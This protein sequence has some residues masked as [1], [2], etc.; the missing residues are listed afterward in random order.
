MVK[1]L[2]ANAGDI[3]ERCRFSPRVGKI[4]R[5]RA[6]QPTPV[7]LPGQSHGQRNLEGYCPLGLKESD[8]TERTEHAHMHT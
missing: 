1:S 5:R 2:P 3:R 8:M 6:W 4:P 7:F